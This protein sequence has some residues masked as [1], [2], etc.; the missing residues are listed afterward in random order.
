MYIVEPFDNPLTYFFNIN[1]ELYIINIFNEVSVIFCEKIN[2]LVRTENFI[3]LRFQWKYKKK[4]DNNVMGTLV[5]IC[6]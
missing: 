1:H 4:N 6:E 3:F 2:K 5:T